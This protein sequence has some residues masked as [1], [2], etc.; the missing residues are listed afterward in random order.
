MSRLQ[1]TAVFWWLEFNFMIASAENFMCLCEEFIRE[2][3]WYARHF[4]IGLIR[5]YDVSIWK[6][7]ICKIALTVCN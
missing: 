5:S 2:T 7:L 3:P 4:V 1:E 6:A